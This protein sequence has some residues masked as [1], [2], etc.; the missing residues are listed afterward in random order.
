[1]MVEWQLR[2][3]EVR[4]PRVLEAFLEVPRHEF[5]LPEHIAEAYED[6]PLPI[7]EGQTISQPYMVAVMTEALQLTGRETVL[8]VG[9]GSGYQTAILARLAGHVYTIER[10]G[11]LSVRA[12]ER[13]KHLGVA[14]VTCFIGDG[15]QGYPEAAP[16]DAILVTAAAPSVPHILVHQLADNGRL[17]IPVGDMDSQ[18]LVQVWKH[19]GAVVQRTINYCRF[20]PLTGKYGWGGTHSA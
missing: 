15:S 10:H 8:E 17:V 7:G 5:V 6:H 14:N 11:S 20:V 12:Q 13:L 2:R 4:D 19:A 9:T 16:F 1:M 3:R 18:E